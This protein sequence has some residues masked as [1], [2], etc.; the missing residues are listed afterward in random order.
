MVITEGK[1]AMLVEFRKFLDDP[2]AWEMFVSGQAGT[3]KTTGLANLIWYCDEIE[4]TNLTCA[5]T[6]KACNILRDKLPTGANISTLHSFLTKRPTLNDNAIEERHITQSKQVGTPDKVQVLF[7]DEYSMVGEKDYLDIGTAQDP[8]YKG[9]PAMKV[10]YIGDPNQLPPVGDT[11]AIYPSGKYNVTLTKIY[12]QAGD[13]ELIET[14]STLVEYIVGTKQAEAL[15]EHKTFTRNASIEKVYKA[16]TND[17]VILAYTNRKVEALNVFIAG[18]DLPVQ[19]DLLYSPTLREYYTY[20]RTELIKDI[21]HINRVFDDKLCF[22]S[23]YKTLEHLLSMNCCKFMRVYPE[24]EENS[25][26]YAVVFGHY[27]YKLALEEFGRVA[28]ESNAKIENTHNQKAKVWAACNPHTPLARARSKAWRDYMTFKDC[29]VCM[30]FPYAMTVHK[31][32]GST[33]DTVFI[34]TKDLAICADHDYKMYLKLL[35]VAIS[36]ASNRVYT[37]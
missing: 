24:D 4:V 28:T 7:I 16:C 37:N 10:V 15:K 18:R 27:E 21:N 25:E 26:V 36:R 5:F 6:H 22:G 1:Y 19:E 32:Q 30:D 14:L 35:Y 29:V 3:G 23:K 12:R 9:K 13:N 2:N 11:K 31:S 17:K 33:F 8:Q 20:K 34:D